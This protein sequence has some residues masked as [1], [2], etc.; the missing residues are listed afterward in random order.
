MKKKRK[1]K[2]KR[3]IKEVREEK[4]VYKMSFLRRTMAEKMNFRKLIS[5][6]MTCSAPGLYFCLVMA[7]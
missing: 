2:R 6:E 4:T 3:E 7:S 5:V 1:S